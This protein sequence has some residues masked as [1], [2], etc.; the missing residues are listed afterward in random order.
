MELGGWFVVVVVGGAPWFQSW[1]TK[2]E[3]ATVPP[4]FW[5]AAWLGL[6]L[7]GPQPRG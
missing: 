2:K 7:A 6:F 5:L 1:F 4:P 3:G